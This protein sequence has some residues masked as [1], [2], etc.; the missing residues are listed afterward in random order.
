MKL[1][2][3]AKLI[4]YILTP[5]II[6]LCIVASIGYK[7]AQDALQN[8]IRADMTII[9]DRTQAELSNITD[10]LRNQLVNASTIQR[11]HALVAADKNGASQHE[12]SELRQYTS[13]AMKNMTESYPLMDEIGLISSNGIILAH[14][15]E[16]LVSSSRSDRAYFKNSINGKHGIETRISGSTGRMTTIISVPVTVYG[17]VEAVLFAS[18][19]TRNL[20]EETS[21]TIKIGRSGTCFVYDMSGMVIMHPD[22]KYVGIEDGKTEWVRSIL[23][24]KQGRIEYEFQGL[25]KIA[26]FR[27]IP[28]MNWVVVIS[29]DSGELLNPVT[30]LFYK[31]LLV[32]TL[33]ALVVGLII[34]Y[35]A[36][37]IAATLGGCSRFVV[38]VAEGNL[39]PDTNEQRALDSARKRT[40]EF[41][42]LANGI[43]SMVEN[44]RNLFAEASQKTEQAEKA[45]EEA[46]KAMEAAEQAKLAAENARREGMLEAAD[47]LEQVTNI[48]SSASTELSAQIE[49]SERGAVDQAARV[50]ET[51][52]AVD[53]MNSTVLEVARNASDAANVSASTK[54]K[55]EEG[56][57]I[58]QQAMHAIG[59]VQKDSLALKGDMGTLAGHARDISQIMSVISDIADQTNLLALNAAIEAARAGEAGRGFAVVADEVRKLAEKTMASTTDVGNAIRSIQESVNMNIAHVD[60]SVNNVEHATSLSRQCGDA[61]REIVDMADATADQVRA[62]ATASEQQSATSEEI[63]LSVGQV[64]TIASETARAMEEAAHAVSDLANQAQILSG[65]IDDM[66]RG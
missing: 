52:T 62:I 32:V 10:M 42:T 53:E 31:N 59:N 63:A 27:H 16:K 35:V 19:N 1:N 8:Q 50:A 57:Q 40:D 47:K 14:T 33:S 17:K 22:E 43:S 44:I 34:F 13:G 30:Q 25:T 36:R 26:H 11:M 12:I 60:A 24:Q 41:A 49:Q 54:A 45:T 3:L 37:N 2:I 61:L 58:V 29:T 64:N 18:I 65:L 7:S 39:T 4:F 48:V 23:Q 15:N 55:A 51:A 9:A 66:K 28:N 20:S 5:A 6:G 56:A 21:D 38:S 46:R